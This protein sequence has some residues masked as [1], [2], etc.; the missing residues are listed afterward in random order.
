MI[1][2]N[3]DKTIVGLTVLEVEGNDMLNL[4]YILIV[5]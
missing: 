2:K 1:R 5:R 4:I 3:V